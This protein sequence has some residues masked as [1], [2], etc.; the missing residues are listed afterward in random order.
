VSAISARYFSQRSAY[1]VSVG[2]V[3]LG[4]VPIEVPRTARPRR[5]QGIRL[6]CGLFFAVLLGVSDRCL[7]RVPSGVDGV[8]SGGVSMVGSLL[9]M[10]H[11]VVLCRFVMMPCG[12]CV[13]F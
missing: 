9:M 3:A 7:F 1:L 4:Q 2:V 6:R 8:C 5:P 10:P 11:I 13:M 12:M